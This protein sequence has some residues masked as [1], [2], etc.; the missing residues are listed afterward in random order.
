MQQARRH[1]PYP[2]TWEIPLAV[3]ITVVLALVLGVHVGRG[4]ANLAAGG[5]WAWPDQAWLFRS[6]PAVLGGDATA[7]VR[8][9]RGADPISLHRWVF[10]SELAITVVLTTVG[11]VV[12]RYWGPHRLKGV[13]TASETERLLGVSRLRRVRRII[14]PDL[15]PT[16]RVGG[17]RS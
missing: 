8:L 14:R 13:A 16:R 9:G 11:A 3:L 1:N 10:V 2:L 6:L 15:S 4:V 12:V 17:G 7:G 5:G